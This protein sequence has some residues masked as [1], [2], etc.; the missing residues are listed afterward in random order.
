MIKVLLILL[1]T[2]ISLASDWNK[3][4][5]KYFQQKRYLAAASAFYKAQAEIKDYKKKESILINL[6]ESFY[7][8]KLYL[9]ASFIYLDL[10]KKGSPRSQKKSYEKLLL[11]YNK[12]HD[13]NLLLSQFKKLELADL[14]ETSK[15]LYYMNLADINYENHNFQESLLALN[16][17]L[18]LNPHNEQALYLKGFIS[19]KLN[20]LDEAI[21]SFQKIIRLNDKLNVNKLKKNLAQANLARAYFQAKKYKEAISTYKKIPYDSPFYRQ[22]LGELAWS[23]FREGQLRSALSTLQSLHTPYYENFFDPEPLILRSIM[24]YFICQYD[25]ADKAL[26]AYELNYSATYYQLLTWMKNSYSP[27]D[28]YGELLLA[29]KNVKATNYDQSLDSYT[30]KIPFYVARSFIED[31]TIS[32]KVSY[33]KYIQTESAQA[34]ASLKGNTT[35]PI[36]KFIRKVYQLR[37]NYVKTE[38]GRR[39]FDLVSEK[40]KLLNEMNNQ[41]DFLKL[42]IL[43]GKRIE[44]KQQMLGLDQ[45]NQ[46]SNR[47]FYIQNGY[48]YWPFQGEFWRDEIG[49]YQYLGVSRCSEKVG[50]Q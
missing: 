45:I 1:S 8:S 19:L 47:D 10:T 17:T 46:E 31:P 42:E 36:L 16:S 35:A 50:K 12:I 48:R 14:S 26:S 28:A 7:Q 21:D 29:Q 33:L 37:T 11:I 5:Q 44:A 32:D 3:E 39:V 23:Q 34:E 20:K 25:E 38:I 22:S 6:G 2:Q 49:N 13:S 4:G 15:D 27:Q 24:Y 9:P 43:D 30:G 40:F 18:D 41:V